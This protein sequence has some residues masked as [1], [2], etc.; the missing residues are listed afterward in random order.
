MFPPLYPS[1]WTKAFTR[2]KLHTETIQLY[3]IGNLNQVCDIDIIYI[4]MIY[5]FV[6]YHDICIILSMAFFPQSCIQ[7]TSNGSLH[8]DIEGG[9]RGCRPRGR[10]RCRRW[11]WTYGWS[12][13]AKPLGGICLRRLGGWSCA[14]GGNRCVLLKGTRNPETRIFAFFAPEIVGLLFAKRKRESIPFGS[15]FQGR[16]C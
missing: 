4:Y 5:E 12:P 3:S 6:W 2:L 10:G 11:C 1:T 7:H 14:V 13:N 8:V 16:K 15:H 9:C